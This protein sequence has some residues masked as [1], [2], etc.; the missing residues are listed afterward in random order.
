MR[1][2][3]YPGQFYDSQIFC[4][5]IINLTHLVTVYIIIPYIIIKLIR[6]S[7]YFWRSPLFTKFI[8]PQIIKSYDEVA[9]VCE[10][11]LT[12]LPFLRDKAKRGLFFNFTYADNLSSSVMDFKDRQQKSNVCGHRF[13]VIK[14]KD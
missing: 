3:P 11:A 1:K 8:Y 5:P 10:G 2:I 9:A 4:G 6:R 7:I 12:T 14:R 13:E